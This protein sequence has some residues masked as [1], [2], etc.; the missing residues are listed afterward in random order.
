MVHKKIKF[1][2]GDKICK[3]M[4]TQNTKL[5]FL[6]KDVEAVSLVNAL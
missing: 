5:A 2:D 6:Q 1:L 4:L 3:K